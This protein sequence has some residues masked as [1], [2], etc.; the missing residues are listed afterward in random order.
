MSWLESIKSTILKEGVR[1]L[2]VPLGIA[3]S[4]YHLIFAYIGYPIGEIHRPLHLAFVLVVLF[5][6]RPKDPLPKNRIAIRGI[7]DTLFIIFSLFATGYLILNAEEIQSRIIYVTPLSTTEVILSLLLIL[8]VL[9]AA[10]RTVGWG[11]TILVSVFLLY[12][13][14]GHYLPGPLG[15]RNYSLGQ[16]LEQVYI[17]KDGL[18]NI[19]L[20]V[21]ANFIF[22]FVLFGALLISSGA[23][24][25]FTDFARELTGRYTGG[26][27]KTAVVSSAF[28]G[29]LSGSSVSNV[30]TTGSF[31]IPAM[32][33]SGYSDTFA[34]GVEAVASSGGQLTPPI[35]GAAAFLMV[36][37]IGVPYL[38]V[39][40]ASLIPAIL[41]FVAVFAMVDL[42]ARRLRLSGIQGGSSSAVISLLFKRG[43]LLIPVVVML[44]LLFEGYTPTLAGFWA[45]ASLLILTLIFD[46]N[47]RRRI[48]F[49]FIE[50]CSEAP[51]LIGS[52]AVACA[53]GGIIAGITVM[54]GLGVKISSII[55]DASMGYKMIALFLTMIIATILGMGMP[56]SGAYIVLAALLAPGLVKMGI[57][58]MAAHMFIIFCAASSTITPPVAISSYAAAAIANTDPIKTSIIAFKLGLSVYII[59]YM[60]VFNPGL[61][62][63]GSMYEI[64]ST[65]LPA[66]IGIICLSIALIGYL[67]IKLKFYERIGFF[68]ASLVLIQQGWQTDLMGFVI[69]ITF[70]ATIYFRWKGSILPESSNMSSS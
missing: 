7:F 15:H 30:V 22:I 43:Y 42:E 3:M 49:I 32:K 59:P 31:T 35:M 17:T 27:A 2:V 4:L 70:I 12:A 19:P 1:G 6:T 28:M 56:T 45:F 52:V 21:S 54:T 14:L 20:G 37:F 39:I 61:I 55:L 40:K 10:H 23:G 5:L 34:A 16:I 60:F 38:E 64:V 47:N 65:F 36:E 29:M 66:I 44:Y 11:L 26:T 68:I 63:E 69:I 8:T 62:W 24:N 41:Y 46:S 25:F 9:E 57:P 48:F 58:I 50:A 18:W 67:L 13:Y 33:K 51:K 53:I